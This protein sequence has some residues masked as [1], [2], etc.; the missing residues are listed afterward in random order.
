MSVL[1]ESLPVNDALQ[2]AIFIEPANLFAKVIKILSKFHLK[3][4]FG[5]Q[6]FYDAYKYASAFCIIVCAWNFMIIS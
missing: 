4:N 1:T 3:I 2:L 5:L 6:S